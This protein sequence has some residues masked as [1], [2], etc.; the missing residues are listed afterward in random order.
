METHGIAIPQQTLLMMILPFAPGKENTSQAALQNVSGKRQA[1]S[2]LS[3]QVIKTDTI[4]NRDSGVSHLDFISR[5]EPE[6]FPLLL[7]ALN[8]IGGCSFA[9][10]AI[11]KNQSFNMCH[12]DTAQIRRN[13]TA[14]GKSFFDFDNTLK[15]SDFINE[16][17]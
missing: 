13:M 15:L 8:C 14:S 7:D 9:R 10:A 6:N 12:A 5:E 11:W 1:V 17:I 3:V 16:R 4:K 2:A